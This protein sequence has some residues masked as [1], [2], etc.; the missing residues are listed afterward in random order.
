MTNWPSLGFVDGQFR[1]VLEA[2]GFDP[3][4]E[5]RTL[6]AARRHGLAAVGFAH[7][8][9]RRRPVRPGQRR[10]DPERRADAPGR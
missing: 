7:T 4:S 3:A 9:G 8:R 2:E 6:T 10:A 5:L 1:E